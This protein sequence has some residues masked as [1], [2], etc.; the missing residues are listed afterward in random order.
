MVLAGV[1]A[2]AGGCGPNQEVKTKP[3]RPVS[4]LRLQRSDPARLDRYTG[5][6]ASWK[7]DQ[8]GF[9]VAGRVEF[10]VELE[11]EIVGDSAAGCDGA[12]GRGT[13]L[14]RLDPTRYQLSVEKAKAEILTAEKQR[15]AAQ[16]EVDSVLPAQQEAAQ[17]AFVL[18]RTELERNQRLVAENAAA[19]RAVDISKAKVDEAKANLRQLEATRE[20]KRAE[21]ASIDARIA[22]LQESLRT[23]ERDLAD[24]QLF[25]SVPGQI[26]E[27]HVIPGSYVERG[28]PVVTVQMMQPIKVEFE[29]A[30][31][32]ART[33]SHRDQLRIYEPQPD[34]TTIEQVAFI[35]TID[36]VADPQT[37]TFTITLML[38]NRKVQSEVPKEFQGTVVARTDAI[39]K[40]IKGFGPKPDALFV[41][42]LNLQQDKEG[43]FVWKILDRQIG[44]LGQEGDRMLKVKKVRVVPGEKHFPVLGLAVVREVRVAEGEELDPAVDLITGPIVLPPGEEENWSGEHVFFDVERWVLRPGDLVGVDLTGGAAQP[45]LYVPLN[46]IVEE[47][48]ANYVFVVDAAEAGDSVRKV[49]VSVHDPVGTLRR[50]E[51]AGGEQVDEG[52]RIVAKGGAFL[53]DGE[54]VNVA[55]E[56]EAQR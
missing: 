8:L 35:Y 9:E 47:S 40:F 53:V 48:G 4:V 45:G 55:E 52:M 18:A 14:A 44:R 17:A 22:E 43:H 38:P 28:Q 2:L 27:V 21:V 50:I 46:A 42:E 19:M 56:V 3:P 39:G 32:T 29:V 34:G 12:A 13:E 24:C 10:V 54:R 15:E 6:V 41:S 49:S 31:A 7:T 1:S 16:I 5:T 30:A 33:L 26:A 11:T 36:P 37:R 51:G 23:A 20:A 25:W